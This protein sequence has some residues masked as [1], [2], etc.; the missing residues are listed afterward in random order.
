MQP[1]RPPLPFLVAL[2]VAAPHAPAQ[3]P[4]WLARTLTPQP[5]AP[6]ASSLGFDPVRGVGILQT[7]AWETWSYD[8]A[9]WTMRATHQ[10]PSPT[11]LIGGSC[12][13]S[14]RQCLVFVVGNQST[15]LETWEWDGA[16][17]ARR[18]VGGMP[19]R[20]GFAL[21]YDAARAQTLLFGGS[22]GSSSGYAEL[23]A[24]NGTIWAQIGNGGPMPR[25]GAA[26]VYDP[27]HQ[28]VVLFGGEGAIAGQLRRFDDTWE[29]NGSYWFNHFGVVG[30]VARYG[31]QM[32]YDARRQRTVLFGGSTGQSS[33]TDT[34]EWDGT[35]WQITLPTGIPQYV[36]TAAY[37]ARRDVTIALQLGGTPGTYEYL[38]GASATASF[39]TF[40]SGCAGP[41]GTP[42][43]AAIAP[44]LPRLGS[45]FQMRLTNLSAGLFALPFG[46][47]GFDATTW[48]GQ[49]LPVSLGAQGMPGCEAW[50][51]PV[52]SE[53][54]T[55]VQGVATWTIPIP[56]NQWF[57]GVDLYVQGGVL[58]PGWNAAGAVVSNAG[59][60]VIGMP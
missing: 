14:A 32:V 20:Y 59:H 46:V 37:D 2:C 58:V 23:W 22:Q 7:N 27:M 54:L 33:P 11:F 38:A 53:A 51:A 3:A 10:G 49:P 29:W 9:A 56:V 16:S 39:T 60:L 41:A 42:Q 17:W 15:G 4:Q 45:G 50:I 26:M 36:A 12:F 24:W 44:S 40:G 6:G 31:H 55:N 19:G 47:V 48:G 5:A 13:D 34:W 18:L 8:G 21:A 43:L 35:S 30:P 1:L 57:L 28:T 25:R 52:W